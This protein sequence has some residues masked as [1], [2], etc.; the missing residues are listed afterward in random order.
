MKVL[1]TGATGLVG[2]EL[3]KLCKKEN[4]AVNYLTTSK[5]KIK[6]Q[7]G[8]CGFYWN[9]KKG[10]IDKACLEGVDKVINLVGASVSKPWTA[11]QKKA[12][13]NSRIDSA[14]LLLKT[15]KENDHQISQIVSASAIGYYPD[16]LTTLYDEDY[17]KAADNFLGKVVTKWEAA[18]DQFEE[19]GLEV[20]K[21]RIGLVLSEKGGALEQIKKPIE[22][23]VGAPLGSGKQWQSWIHLEDLARIFLFAIQKNLDGVYNGVA[24]NPV[25]NK[26]LTYAI[27]KKLN[28]PLVLP[29]VPKFALKLA[30]G[31]RSSL[32]LASQLVSNAKLDAVGFIYYYNHI[33]PALED[34]I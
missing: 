26:R 32:V 16:S 23:Y 6:N 1:I 8:Y 33:G 27:A 25:T 3:V 4:I 10:K 13:I 19:E 12:I 7:P 9:P 29:N 34:L 21:I 22:N 20:A 14:N 18:V 31:E 2:S 28:R 30:L 5:E 24:P 15:L 17:P 11:S